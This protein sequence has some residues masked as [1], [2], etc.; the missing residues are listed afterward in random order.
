[1]K[2]IMMALM[3]LVSL[4]MASCTPNNPSVSNPLANTKWSGKALE[5]ELVATFTADECYIQASGYASGVAV[6]SYKTS[7]SDI[8]ITITT[9]SGDFDGQLNKGDILIAS[10]N[11]TAQT[12]SLDITL[13]GQKTNVVLTKLGGSSSG[14]SGN[15]GNSGAVD[16]TAE[17]A[18]GTWVCTYL[19]EHYMENGKME[20]EVENQI[21]IRM[22][23][24]R[25]YTYQFYNNSQTPT[26]SGQWTLNGK[27][28][29]FT[30][31]GSVGKATVEELTA[32]KLKLRI[33]GS[34]SSE[35]EVYYFDRQ[36]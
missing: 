1:M 20:Y 14:N 31:S 7:N 9:T 4:I 16:V 28:A 34:S 33:D 36:Q 3:C 27:S 22:I 8:F 21:F 23:L 5:T 10:L 35:Y 12:I 30:Y 18:F 19:E 25:D 2:K 17:N 29:T 13:Y 26:Y 15:S 11:T 24:N 6:G 32:K